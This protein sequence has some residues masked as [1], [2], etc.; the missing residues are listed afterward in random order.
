MRSRRTPTSAAPCRQGET[1]LWTQDRYPDH[2]DAYR[3]R[4]LAEEERLRPRGEVLFCEVRRV[5]ESEER[6]VTRLS[7]GPMARQAEE[8]GEVSSPPPG[9]D[10]SALR[11]ALRSLSPRSRTILRLHAH[12][13]THRAIAQRTGLC[14]Q[15]ISQLIAAAR[16]RVQKHYRPPKQRVA[17]TSPSG[18]CHR[19]RAAAGGDAR[20]TESE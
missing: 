13:L 14:P 12:G 6:L 1:S 19:E 10:R 9:V 3:R 5:A 7:S 18:A 4:L 20:V 16:R 15:R 17:S 11:S 2:V 8:E